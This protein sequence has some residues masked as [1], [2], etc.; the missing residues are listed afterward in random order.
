MVTLK[1]LRPDKRPFVL[2]RATFSGG[3]RFASVWTGDNAATWEHLQL[4]NL[5]C[6]RLA[7]SGFSFVGTDIGGFNKNPDGELFIR[8]LQLAVFHP[9]YRVHSM[10]NNVDGAAEA[11][12]ELIQAAEQENRMDQE[13]WSFG[14]DNTALARKAIELRYQLLPYIYTAFYQYNKTGAPVIRSLFLYS[15]EDPAAIGREE[16]FLFGGHL[17]VAPILEPGIEKVQ[18]YLPKGRWYDYWNGALYEGKQMATF[19]VRPDRIPILAK[20]GAV[21]PN[22]PV[23]QYVGEQQFE[24]ITLRIYCGEG[25]STLYE[26]AGE[27]YGYREGG[28]KLRTFI[29][30]NE[31]NSFSIAQ[32]IRGE[33]PT[34][35]HTFQLSFFGLSFQVSSCR[36]DGQEVAFEQDGAQLQAKVAK[37]FK[38]VVLK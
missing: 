29:T 38:E 11:E 4:A 2:T 19:E 36:A 3:Q 7:A 26:D 25:H 5:Q 27:G 33:Y 37:G 20:A 8:W 12:A 35:Y 32:E 14:E 13:P 15:Q 21:I 30:K 24:E 9:L 17:L 18:V 28:Y 16:E 1:S 31:G 34:S 10:G 6:Q 23:Q 22:Y